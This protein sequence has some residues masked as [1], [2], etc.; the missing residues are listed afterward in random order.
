MCHGSQVERLAYSFLMLGATPRSRQL[1]HHDPVALDFVQI[2]LDRCGSLRR[3]YIRRLDRAE[4]FAFGAQQDDPPAA[5][6]ALGEL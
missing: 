1:L 2:K 6:H 3:R 5:A 4:D